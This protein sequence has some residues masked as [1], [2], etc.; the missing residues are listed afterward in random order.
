V[1]TFYQGQKGE[2]A[3]VRLV[4]HAARAG[5]LNMGGGGRGQQVKITYEKR[6][7]DTVARIYTS[8]QE[9]KIEKE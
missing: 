5:P 4:C 9:K 2:G 6:D 1:Y 7:N 3:K 8:Q